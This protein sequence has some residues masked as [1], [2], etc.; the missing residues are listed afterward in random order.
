MNSEQTNLEIER[1]FLVEAT[2]SNLASYPSKEIEQGYIA[3]AEETE[4]RVRRKGAQY[5]L[6]VK[7]GHGLVREETEILIEQSQFTPLWQLT[8]GQRV[9]KIRYEIPYLSHLI[10]VDVYQ[11]S[12][13]PLITADVEFPSLEASKN[14]TPS[15]WLGNEISGIPA[16]ANKNLAIMGLPKNWRAING[17]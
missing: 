8:S 5:F 10:E 2:P 3:I 7:K 13:A 11:E 1:K 15:A 4:V 16:F 12:L 17:L 9:Q 14:F 6:T